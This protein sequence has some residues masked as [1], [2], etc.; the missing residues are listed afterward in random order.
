MSMTMHEYEQ[1]SVRM[2]QG[3]EMNESKASM[4]IGTAYVDKTKQDPPIVVQM[5]ILDKQ[6][7]VL[8]D[9]IFQLESK[10]APILQEVP[11]A[12]QEQAP[13]IQKQ[14]FGSSALF[15]GLQSLNGHVARLQARIIEITERVEV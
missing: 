6:L 15:N 5:N 4:V 13:G 10:L 7:S 11:P 9:H 1:W 8:Q 3:Q 14:P 2:K 12:P